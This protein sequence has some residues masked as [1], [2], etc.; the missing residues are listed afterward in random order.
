MSCANYI[1]RSDNSVRLEWPDL[2]NLSANILQKMGKVV[3]L[4]AFDKF[5]VYW[6]L[7]NVRLQMNTSIS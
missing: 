1:V 4:L 2:P 3:V 7:T 5:W 6:A